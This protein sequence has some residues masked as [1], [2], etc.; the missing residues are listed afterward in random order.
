M[1]VV[2]QV[3]QEEKWESGEG[4]LL[5]EFKCYKELYQNKITQ[6]ESLSKQLRK[7]QKTIKENEA[8]YTEQVGHHSILMTQIESVA[9]DSHDFCAHCSLSGAARWLYPHGALLT[10]ACTLRACGLWCVIAEEVLPGPAEP[11]AHQAQGPH[12]RGPQQLRY[13]SYRTPNEGPFGVA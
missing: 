6:Q 7:Q 9:Q 2:V 8:S 5:P 1:R 13:E 3:R 12:Q 11:A 4:R 10:L